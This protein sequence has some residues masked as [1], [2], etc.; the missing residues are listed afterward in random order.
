M[1]NLA[2]NL[3]PDQVD[4]N[5]RH[6]YHFVGQAVDFGEN[7]LGLIIEPRKVYIQDIENNDC[8]G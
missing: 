2:L 8:Q 5:G 3:D 4:E 6:I 7:G 1:A